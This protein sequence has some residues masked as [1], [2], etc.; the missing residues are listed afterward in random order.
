MRG[1]G[2]LPG[3]RPE[4]ELLLAV[5]SVDGGARREERL[6]DILRA[7]LDGR[8]LVRAARQNRLGGLVV[9]ALLELRLATAAPAWLRALESDYRRTK[10]RNLS[11]LRELLEIHAA[12]RQR[13]IESV[14][15][16]GPILAATLYEDLGLRQFKDLDFLVR[17]EDLGATR[18]LLVERGYRALE[19]FDPARVKEHLA[20]DCEFHFER[21][22]G[23]PLV[24]VH[25]Q[26]LPRQHAFAPD[27][28]EYWKRLVPIRIAGAQVMVF[29]PEDLLVVLCVHHGDKHLWRRLR[30][31]GD[32]ARLLAKRP[33]LDWSVALDRARAAGRERALLL[34]AY[35]ASV[36]LDAPLPDPVRDRALRDGGIAAEAGLVRG[37]LFREDEGLPRYQ[38]W[39]RYVAANSE[40]ARGRGLPV[41]ESAGFFRYLGAVLRPEWSDRQALPLPKA[42]SPLYYLYRPA[43]LFARHRAGLL[44]RI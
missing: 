29:P 37:R 4:A 2:L 36:F 21:P 34:G 6:R 31:I 39:R 43:R 1:V 15:Y 18:A 19:S 10:L 33:D 11:L 5:A 44:R 12:L 20:V 24:E 26:I 25:W 28:A 27:L 23:E 30:W 42:L 40:R 7:D 14:P 17:P 16:K 32:V 9:H 38:E 13:G 41:P 8:F 3:A 35:L 22:G